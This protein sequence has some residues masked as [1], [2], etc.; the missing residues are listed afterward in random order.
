MLNVAVINGGRGASG[1]ISKLLERPYINLTSIVNAYDDGKSTGE[2]RR[3][4]EMLGPSDIRKVQQLMLPLEDPHYFNYQKLFNHRFS[5]DIK[6]DDVFNEFKNYLYSKS[7]TLVG[8]K[9]ESKYIDIYLKKFLDIFLNT[10]STIEKLRG[11]KFNFSD[12]SVMNCIYAGAFLHFNRNIADSSLFLGKLFNLR[13]NV[14]STSIENKYLVALRE[15]GEM[16][17]SESEIVELRSNVRIERIFLLDSPLPKESFEKFS[18]EEKRY[19]LN[20]HNC[21]VPVSQSVI[22]TLKQADIIIYSAGTQHS[23][24]YPSYIS[25]GLSETIANNKKATKIFVTNIGADY[26]TPKYKASDY[27]LGAFKYLNLTGHRNYE[28]D[29]LFDYIF[30]NKGGNMDSSSYVIFDEDAFKNINIKKIIK[31]F[32]SNEFPGKHNGDL[33]TEEILNLNK[34]KLMNS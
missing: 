32:E 18:S 14:I 23:S 33:L 27:F 5:E 28:M 34:N 25:T 20:Q 19:Y 6:R 3:F 13:G 2:I 7:S 26:E 17:Y 15:N 21:H 9:I 8:V 11:T 24:L 10:L 4:F 16:L 29:E 1:L 31:N 30:I 12:C 22:L